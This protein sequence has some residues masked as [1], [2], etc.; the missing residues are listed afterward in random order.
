MPKESLIG[1]E[2]EAGR[3]LLQEFKDWKVTGFKPWGDKVGCVNHWRSSLL[4]YQQVSSNAFR[5]QAQKIAKTALEQMPPQD[6]LEEELDGGRNA[7]TSNYIEKERNPGATKNDNSHAKPKN[8]CDQSDKDEDDE[9]YSCTLGDVSSD[10]S[11]EGFA[12]IE[13]GELQNSRAPFLSEYPSGNKLLVI[14]PLD[15]N[16]RDTSANQFEFIED[17]TAVQRLGKVPKEREHS[18]A[19][20]GLGSEKSSKLGFSDVD[21]MVV[22]AEIQRRFKANNYKQDENGDVWE[23]RATLRLPY[24]CEPKLYSKDAKVLTSF[25]MM[26]NKRGF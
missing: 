7:V 20:I 8:D 2:T 21:L 3:Q 23:I 26:N 19:L 14:F 17:N 5:K 1:P 10:D 24:K 25:R 9:D 22:D 16:V 15:G 13:L 4:L 6:C 18:V 12:D 11:L